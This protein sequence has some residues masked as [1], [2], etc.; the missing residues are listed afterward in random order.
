MACLT[1][2][3]AMTR[4]LRSA[5]KSKNL[6]LGL[7]LLAIP[8]ICAVFAPL[9]APHDPSAPSRIARLQ[10]PSGQGGASEYFLGTDGLGRDL[11]SRLIYGARVSLLVGLTVVL[12]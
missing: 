6:L 3:S 4:G 2:G 10:P 7:T 9:L 5:F 1:L 11:L 12:I 8:V